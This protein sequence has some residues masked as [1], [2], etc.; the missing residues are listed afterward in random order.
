VKRTLYLRTTWFC[1]VLI[2]AM[3]VGCAP[4]VQSPETSQQ[5]TPFRPPTAVGEFPLTDDDAS[6][7]SRAGRDAEATVP[8]PNP[9]TPVQC[10]T[11]L[12]FLKDLTIPDGTVVAAE[13][14]LDKRWEVHNSGSCNWGENYRVRLIAGS[15]LGAQREQALYPARSDS[16]VTIRIVFI[17][18]TEPGSYRSAW[19]A[20]NPQ[21][22]PFGDPFFIEFVVR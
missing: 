10:Q 8:N 7:S 22:E 4:A 1:L 18:P 13:S 9:T 3:L 6:S 12:T 5:E 11:N 15:E 17:A 16:R 20:F 14:T 2:I 21:G 19:Q